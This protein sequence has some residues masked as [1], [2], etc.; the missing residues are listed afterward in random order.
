[1]ARLKV[2]IGDIL[3]CRTDSIDVQS[4]TVYPLLGV[5]S[6]GKGAFAAGDLLGSETSYT[7]LMSCA[8]G[9]VVYPKLMA[10]E[11][12]FDVV[13]H[14]LS[15]RHVSPE[16]C[17]FDIDGSSATPA[18]VREFL[19]SEH[20]MSQ[21]KLGSTGTNVR[22][23]RLQPS[24]FEAIEIPLPNIEE[25]EAIAEKIVRYSSDTEL[26]A[27]EEPAVER[28][29]AIRNQ[30]FDSSWPIIPLNE[31]LEL[32]RRK[33][34]VA[35]DS[36]YVEIGIRSFGGGVFHKEPRT[37][38]DIGSKK[39]FSISPGD[40]LV[41]NVFA[42]EGA[43]AVAKDSELGKIGSHR[44]M[45]WTPLSE[46]LSVD[47]VAEYLVSHTGLKQLIKASPGSA[48][49]NKTLSI[50]SFRAMEIPLP[51]IATQKSVVD[52]ISKLRNV[53]RLVKQRRLLAEALPR[54]VRNQIF[55]KLM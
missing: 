14:E 39:V 8:A 3:Q 37:G 41:S 2:K 47:Y 27:A 17:V 53:E 19:R 6:F 51:D 18:Y 54:S 25:Q 43:V 50:A 45:T 46:G 34:E 1:M 22:R 7:K 38:S 36:E 15:G 48:G 21:V 23:R 11:G 31:V 28:M 20:F 55:S 42:W 12:A 49:R 33:I 30:L 32:Q 16:F 5:R 10:W 9:Q 26:K 29:D 52:Q 4:E 35:V 13:S 40:L 24:Q 44:F